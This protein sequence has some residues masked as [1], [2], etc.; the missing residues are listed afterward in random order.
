MWF[1]LAILVAVWL[2]A[3]WWARRECLPYD[4]NN[5]DV[6]TYLF[7]AESFAAGHFVRPTPEPREFYS[8]WQAIVRD[9]SFAYY[10]PLPAVAMALPIAFGGS[11]FLVPWLSS[12]LA[13]VLTFIW[14]RRLAG[15][16]AAWFGTLVLAVS[17]FFVANG[18]SVL[19]HAFTLLLTVAFLVVVERWRTTGSRRWAVVAGA[20]LAAVFASRPVNALA[21]GIAW[22]PWMIL[23]RR[24]KGEGR[25]LEDELLGEGEGKGSMGRRRVF[26][27][28]ISHF[29]LFV[30]GFAALFVPL[31]LYYY[32]L[33]GR[34]T[35]SLFTDYWPRNRF[36]FG[37][38]LGRG[39]PGHYFQTFTNHDFFGFL[40]NLWYS[41]EGLATWWTG[42]AWLSAALLGLVGILL[43]LR[44]G[45]RIPSIGNRFWPLLAWPAAHILL[46]AGYFTPST[47]TTGPR[48]LAE[49]MPALALAAGWGM[50]RLATGGVARRRLALLI[51]A[52]AMVVSVQ[53]V[54]RF[55]RLNQLGIPARRAVEHGVVGEARAPA[56]VFLRSFWIGHP[57][58]IFRNL[59]SLSGP[60]IFA[61]DRG[62]E[63]RRLVE[64]HPERNAYI[65]A[66]F[67]EGRG[68]RAELVPVYRASDRRWLRAPESVE[69]PFFI[70]SRFILPLRLEGDAAR[71]LFYP[72]A[73]EI[74]GQ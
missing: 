69:A 4:V 52:V 21:L 25:G 34:W 38:G 18:L 12:G 46:Y 1:P 54:V 73:E 68:V 48:Y 6:G 43:V 61:C 20:L 70:G 58:P 59:P 26:S 64:R 71:K 5:T 60:L 74:E 27:F 29:S 40:G 30:G 47:P 11:P 14:I 16:H 45:N 10:P 13:L 35:L 51:F 65:L 42:N 9:R 53:A 2:A 56:V 32:E 28:L 50:A 24:E 57:L 17:P 3:A 23:V 41:A 55:L 22:V 15:K 31:A 49:L 36:G 44:I 8:Q 33:A 19:S 66:L 7:Q 39:E 37:Q 67:P 63:D 72:R 62:A